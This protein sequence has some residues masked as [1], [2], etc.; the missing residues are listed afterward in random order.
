MIA[1]I[2]DRMPDNTPAEAYVRNLLDRAA[3]LRLPELF[4]S[5]PSDALYYLP[6]RHGVSVVVL[7]T[8]SL[9]HD[10]LIKIMTYRLAQYIAINYVDTQMV[11]ETRLEH[12]PLT[13]VS[14]DDI[15]IL[16]GSADSGEIL[17]Y[18]VMKTVTTPPAVTFRTRERAQFPV[19]QVFG[20]GVFNRLQ[21]LPD[22]PLGQVREMGRFVKNQQIDPISEMAARAPAEVGVAILKLLS[23][24]LGTEVAACIGDI[25]EGVAK[26]NLD[27][28]HIPTVVIH[29]VIPYVPEDAFVFPGC[30]QYRTRYP[31]AFL[32]SDIPLAR[33]AAIEAALAQPGRQGIR[34]LLALRRDT[35]I[36]R[37]SLL[38]SEGLPVLTDMAVQQ[39]G[40]MMEERRQLLRI[41]EWLRTTD[42]FHSLTIAEATVLATLMERQE[43]AAGDVIVRQGERGGDFYLIAAGQAD[44]HV[45]QH[46]G[47]TP[48][49][50]T[51][52]PGD[53]FGEIALVIGTRQ[54]AD[55]IAATPM[56]LLLLSR[57]VY[58]LYLAP[59]PE[60]QQQL[61]RT[62]L[63]RSHTLS[64][65]IAPVSVDQAPS[66]RPYG[67][68]DS[69]MA[70]AFTPHSIAR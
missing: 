9:N 16:A 70:L 27:L 20:W 2:P 12:E 40:V 68:L 36:A 7:R 58:T 32:C 31:F 33:L 17:C 52:G 37:S 10:Q 56:V 60:I 54:M 26:R 38:P 14:P 43:V 51:L 45:G 55:I 49:A 15:H 69:R 35:L 4:A 46:T 65:A 39:E 47:A 22:L 3:A 42:L 13:N 66:D 62:A 28:F 29:G 8:T 59:H 53:Y 1:Q 34:A 23:G 63:Q 57:E 18:M 61:I 44:L 67:P 25:E 11:Y 41:G 24:A 50:D 21:I 64:K 6:N 5:P 48:P 30:Y 19:E